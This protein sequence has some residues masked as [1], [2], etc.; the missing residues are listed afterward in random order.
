MLMQLG[1]IQELQRSIQLLDDA[2]LLSKII[3]KRNINEKK[4]II[5]IY[6]IIV[7]INGM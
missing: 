6:I 3:S 4:Y 5:A 1:G 2:R 7:I